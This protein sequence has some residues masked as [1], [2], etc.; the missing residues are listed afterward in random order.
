[1]TALK[2]A[3]LCIV[4]ENRRKK[5]A[6]KNEIWANSVKREAHSINRGSS[7]DNIFSAVENLLIVTKNTNESTDSVLQS[8]I[9]LSSD[10]LKDNFFHLGGNISDLPDLKKQTV[11]VEIARMWGKDIIKEGERGIA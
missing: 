3:H 9:T 5:D 2:E 10:T 4:D 11:T 7:Y 1:M 6:V 8:I